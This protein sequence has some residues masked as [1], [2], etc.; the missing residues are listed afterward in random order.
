M[1]VRG[2]GGK[3]G[4]RRAAGREGRRARERGRDPAPSRGS[5][6][7]RGGACV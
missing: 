7:G 5:E 2:A 3:E 6:G 4:I 1:E